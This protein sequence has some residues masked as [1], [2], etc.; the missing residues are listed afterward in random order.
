MHTAL[1]RPPLATGRVLCLTIPAGFVLILFLLAYLGYINNVWFLEDEGWDFLPMAIC[2]TCFICSS[3][4]L[5]HVLVA[6]GSTWF[7][8]IMVVLNVFGI[9]TAS[10]LFVCVYAYLLLWFIRLTTALQQGAAP[11]DRRAVRV[12]YRRLLQ[13]TGRFR[14]RSR[15]ADRQAAL[16]HMNLT[17]TLFLIFFA[18]VAL[19]LWHMKM[20][21]EISGFAPKTRREKFRLYWVI[22]GGVNIVAFLSHVW[23][24][25]GGIALPGG[26]RLVGG[27]YLVAQHG[28][29]F[30]FTPSRYFLSYWHGVIFII[31]HLICSFAIWR[32][33]DLKG[34][35]HDNAA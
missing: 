6:T 28:R 27:V 9:A 11:A 8:V 26:G 16:R 23:I 34:S 30:S 10:L 25:H 17:I 32:L 5:G 33:R 1:N 31:V 24:D 4:A 29:D 12:I 18:L 13:P 35:R 22:A 2:P 3:L 19:V 7:R 15:S 20:A 14:R 21:G